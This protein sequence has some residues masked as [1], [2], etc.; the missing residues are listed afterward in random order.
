MLRRSIAI[1][2]IV[3][4]LP[5]LAL[6]Q[7]LSRPLALGSEGADVTNLQKILQSQGYLT[8]AP[9]GYFGP[10]TKLAVQKFQKA[11]GIPALGGVGPATSAVLSKI[12]VPATSA[13]GNSK[14][15]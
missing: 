15:A 2:S 4:L 11:H 3:L 1:A 5:A 14:Q 7:T 9:S 8:A 12:S 13:S 6:A 10:L